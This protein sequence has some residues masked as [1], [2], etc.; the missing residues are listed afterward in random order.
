LTD[1]QRI[2][3]KWIVVGLIWAVLFIIGLMLDG[4]VATWV[5]T[6][7]IDTAIE[8]HWITDRWKSPGGFGFTV[9]VVIIAM[10]IGKIDL[11]DGGFILLCGLLAAADVVIKWVIGRTRPFKLGAM[12]RAMPFTLHPFKDGI[13]GFFHQKDLS[14]PSGHEWSAF[15][16]AMGIAM[17][18]PRWA[19]FFFFVAFAVGVERV[20]EN[21]HFITD[22]LVAMPAAT[23]GCVIAYRLVRPNEIPNQP[24]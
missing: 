8:G 22:V 13:W 17:I 11:R 12:D 18:R 14:F 6:H 3:P 16:L 15:A 20:L 24:V 23:V 19:W 1:L 4:P 5:H 2:N 21:A 7:G 10:A 9:V